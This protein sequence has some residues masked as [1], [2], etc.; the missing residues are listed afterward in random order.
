[1]EILILLLAAAA[2]GLLVFLVFRGPQAGND[3]AAALAPRLDALERLQERA[4]RT[5][6]DE[7]ALSRQAAEDQ[8]RALRT[9]LGT[10]LA[11]NREAVDR[12]LGE[13][14]TQLQQ[15]LEAFG[16]RLT[17]FG[18]AEAA[19]SQQTRTELA[20]AF[21]ALRAS[22]QQQATDAA[23]A[24]LRQQEAASAQANALSERLDRKFEE[25][26][27]AVET[28]LGQL[29]ADNTAKLEEMRRTVDEKLQGTLEKR[30]GESFKL[31]SERLEQVHKGLGEMQSLATGVGDLRRMLT[32]VKT[33]GTWGE[34]QLAALL[35]QMLNP[36]QYE[37]NVAPVPGSADRVEFAIRLPGRQAGAPQ[38]WLPIDAKFPTEDYDRLAAA[39]ERADAEQMAVAAKA[40][41]TRVKDQARTIAAK[42]LAPPHTT[43]FGV[44]FLTTE[45]LYAE[46]LR[47]PGLAEAIQREH[48]V[49]VAGPT[50]LAALL[51][52]LQ[53]GFR[54]LAIEQ[55]ASEVW[56]VLGAVKTEFGRFGDTLESVQRKL[57]AA[58]KEIEKTGVRSRAI[59]R[60]LRDVEALPAAEAQRVLPEAETTPSAA[61][62]ERPAS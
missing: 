50:T 54:T 43:D 24:Q 46:V 26:R 39:A 31:V 14:A 60:K 34:V 20:Q 10:T 36:S 32:N 28:K 33:R 59:E 57:D 23:V 9:E 37:A 41:A 56:Q 47:Q 2:V 17:D 38:V 7:F 4:E 44:L 27:L 22:L 3:P 53:V 12:R 21:Q 48:R 61:E 13:N 51:N 29:Q 5:L 6:K 18:A 15:Q 49:I 55:R 52:S 25:L 42:Y 35:E 40:L 58:T 1:M 16:R 45:G 19:A 8:A 30:L 11:Q 62:G